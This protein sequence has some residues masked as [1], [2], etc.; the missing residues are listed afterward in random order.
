VQEGTL[1]RNALL[2][3]LCYLFV[4]AWL[5]EPRL[6]LGLAPFVLGMIWRV[7]VSRRRLRG[8][9]IAAALTTARQ[10]D[11]TVVGAPDLLKRRGAES[12]A[13]PSSVWTRL[14]RLLSWR[15]LT[16]AARRVALVLF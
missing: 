14:G 15:R 8:A 16:N 13:G 7:G 2:V 6:A 12:A 1:F 11:M 10:L 9:M 4:L 5:L 3:A